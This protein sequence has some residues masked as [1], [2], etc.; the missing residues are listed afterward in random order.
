MDRVNLKA[1]ETDRGRTYYG[2]R[3]NTVLYIPHP[4]C[5]VPAPAY[6]KFPVQREFEAADRFP[7]SVEHPSVTVACNIPDLFAG[8]RTEG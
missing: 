3:A 1:D 2:M 7:V 8:N 4:H 5:R 6:Q